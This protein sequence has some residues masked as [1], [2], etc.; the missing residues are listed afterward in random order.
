MSYGI[1]VK[2]EFGEDVFGGP[3]FWLKSKGSTSAA[4]VADHEADTKIRFPAAAGWTSSSPTFTTGGCGRQTSFSW[5]TSANANNTVDHYISDGLVDLSTYGGPSF[6]QNNYAIGSVM[7]PGEL[8]FFR[9][10]SNGFFAS[11]QVFNFLPEFTAGQFM[12][13]ATWQETSPLPYYICSTTPGSPAGSYG[14]QVFDANGD[15]EFDSRQETPRIVDHFYVPSA[16]ARSVLFDNAV[17]DIPL[18]VPTATPMV[19]VPLWFHGLADVNGDAARVRM[20]LHDSSTIRLS[21][22]MDAGFSF[23][24]L[25]AVYVHD[26]FLTVAL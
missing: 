13:I 1:T 8:A 21:R 25:D 16:D 17:I 7:Q 26:A 2:N 12:H 9:L 3:L 15:I 23:A 5:A 18:T 6:Y 11:E 4:T 20:H 24:H 10:T 19:S 14:L 22:V